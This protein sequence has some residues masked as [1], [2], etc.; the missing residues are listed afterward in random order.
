M[1][2]QNMLSPNLSQCW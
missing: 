1:M 2:H